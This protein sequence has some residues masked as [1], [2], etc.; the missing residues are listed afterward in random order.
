MPHQL[1]VLLVTAA[2]IALF[3]T[4]LGPDHYLPFVVMA[5]AAKWSVP[6]TV[7]VTL[8]CG[9]GHVGSSVLLGLL[10]VAFGLA[11]SSLEAVER[12]RGD[13]AAWLLTGFGLVYFIW[14]L[15]RAFR[16]RPHHDLHLHENGLAHAH[17][18]AHSGDHL[19]VHLT[20]RPATLTPWIL[21]VI[22]V[23]GPCEPLIPLLI[24]PAA[25]H[26]F[27]AV[28]LVSGVFAAVTIATM[29]AIVLLGV[30][31]MSA[32]PWKKLQPYSHATAGAA[33]FLCGLAIL[34]LGL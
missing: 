3:H 24:Y 25:Q 4:V 7:W 2:S 17:L 26:H 10:G 23:F 20:D 6:K 27:R 30:V 9:L 32:V 31:G 19:H 21:F 8:L 22:F 15:R 16:Q 33:I 1:T 13:I 11:I 5:R 14:G 34:L 18:H 12:V 29:L 28:A